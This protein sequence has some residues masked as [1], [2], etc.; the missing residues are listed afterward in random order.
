MRALAFGWRCHSAL[1]LSLIIRVDGN[2]RPAQDNW[3]V[4]SLQLNYL[5][6]PCS[7]PFACGGKEIA[8]RRFLA[9]HIL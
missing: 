3:M 2:P 7:N 1:L 9:L 5:R 8:E 6:V 4:G